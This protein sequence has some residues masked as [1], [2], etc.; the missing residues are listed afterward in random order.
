[1]LSIAASKVRRTA[2]LVARRLATE[3]DDEDDN[4]GPSETQESSPGRRAR[5]LARRADAAPSGSASD[6]QSSDASRPDQHFWRYTRTLGLRVIAAGSVGRTSVIADTLRQVE[7]SG[8]DAVLRAEKLLESMEE[9]VGGGLGAA[10]AA[11]ADSSSGAEDGGDE[12]DGGSSAAS[13]P[14]RAGAT[15]DWL[16]LSETLRSAAASLAKAVSLNRAT[17]GVAAE[18]GS[19]AKSR[20]DEDH[21]RQL[22]MGSSSEGEAASM[23][24]PTAGPRASQGD[25][26]MLQPRAG[27]SHRPAQAA[28]VLDSEEEEDDDDDSEGVEGNSSIFGSSLARGTSSADDSSSPQR[29]KHARLDAVA[30]A[31]FALAFPATAVSPSAACRWLQACGAAGD[32]GD[33]MLLRSAV[34][35]AVALAEAAVSAAT[36]MDYALGVVLESAALYEG[37]PHAGPCERSRDAMEVLRE[38]SLRLIQVVQS[39][40]VA[41]QAG[42]LEDGPGGVQAVCGLA[43]ALVSARDVASASVTLLANFD[44]ATAINDAALQVEGQDAPECKVPPGTGDSLAW[45]PD[46][47]GV[48]PRRVLPAASS[49]WGA[50]ADEAEQQLS[51]QSEL[52]GISGA[53]RM[54]LASIGAAASSGPFVP[55]PAVAAS[56]RVVSDLAGMRAAVSAGAG[57]TSLVRGATQH[58]GL[59]DTERLSLAAARAAVAVR[60]MTSGLGGFA[61]RREA[62]SD[63][64]SAPDQVGVT[65]AATYGRMLARLCVPGVATVAAEAIA[66]RRFIRMAPELE[67]VVALSDPSATPA[68]SAHCAGAARVLGHLGWWHQSERA[69]SGAAK[70]VHR[71]FLARLP[72][73][74]VASG[75]EVVL[76]SKAGTLLAATA[77][78]LRSAALRHVAPAAAGAL[79][80]AAVLSARSSA[81]AL[82]ASL[83][84]HALAPLSAPCSTV[85]ASETSTAPC[86]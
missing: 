83:L 18:P 38:A 12:T 82:R 22:W 29:S 81:E 73:A 55:F 34:G 41:Q 9:S 56:L 42:S 84:A 39:L 49:D 54:M 68:A 45:H 21:A 61:P 23:Q 6:G 80:H 52:Q 37:A 71:E 20:L 70:G 48:V 76:A 57:G 60:E 13:S 7:S 24:G 79:F 3:Q 74:L 36:S 2:R 64:A 17:Q 67:A 33:E 40:A 26:E 30:A 43:H 77:S 85:G 63:A 62:A 69:A 16:S 75:S 53:S 14:S 11:E 65:T 66:A 1:M 5:A 32:A 31:G 25:D 4:D 47:G 8:P 19:A 51:L 59:R 27:G 15:P 50:T 72:P 86:S 78:E 46:L 28:D 35:P 58:L 10:D 44:T